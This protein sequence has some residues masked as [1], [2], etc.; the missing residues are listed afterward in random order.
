MSIFFTKNIDI[1]AILTGLNVILKVRT[2][3]NTEHQLC[4]ACGINLA[5]CDILYNEKNIKTNMQIWISQIQ[6]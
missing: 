6:I 2:F 1:T 5:V 3:V 4:F